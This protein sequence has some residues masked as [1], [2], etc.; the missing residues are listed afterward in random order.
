MSRRK[1]VD[2]IRYYQRLSDLRRLI[3]NLIFQRDECSAYLRDQALLC[4][5]LR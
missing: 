5:L 2:R 3:Y 4:L 1:D